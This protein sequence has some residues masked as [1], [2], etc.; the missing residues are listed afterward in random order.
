[1]SGAGA[2]PDE[3]DETPDDGEPS[4]HG[5]DDGSDDGGTGDVEPVG[6]GGDTDPD[7]AEGASPGTNEDGDPLPQAVTD[8]RVGTHDGFDRVMFGLE[9]AVGPR[10]ASSST[11]SPSHRDRATRSRSMVTRR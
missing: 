5:A 11:T 4:E 2:P 3:N 10:A 1:M 7:E 8:V 9:S 6:D